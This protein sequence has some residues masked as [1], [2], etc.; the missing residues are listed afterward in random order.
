MLG[1]ITASQT[2]DEKKFP[3]Q[4]IQSGAHWQV[5]ENDCGLVVVPICRVTVGYFRSSARGHL[6]TI[7]DNT[8]LLTSKHMM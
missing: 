1:I 7:G 3:V 5:T 4:Q 2:L 6:Q 8:G